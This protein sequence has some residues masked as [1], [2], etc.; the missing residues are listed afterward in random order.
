[1]IWTDNNSQIDKCK[2][3]IQTSHAHTQVSWADGS[4]LSF[5]INIQTEWLIWH[6]VLIFN[7][8]FLFSCV[9]V[10]KRFHSVYSIVQLEHVILSLF[11]L[12]NGAQAHS[13]TFTKSSFAMSVLIV[14]LF[15]RS[16]FSVQ[17]VNSVEN[18]VWL[19]KMYSNVAYRRWIH[20]LFKS[21]YTQWSW[22]FDA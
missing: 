13:Q 17:I 16:L 5:K 6:S 1:M 19:T 20:V 15:F 14:V 9:N 12:F 21:N 11:R 3:T 8:R 22:S 7:E 2:W 4:Q 10:Y 18:W